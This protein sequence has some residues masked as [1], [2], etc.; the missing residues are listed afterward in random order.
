MNM[1]AP[2]AVSRARRRMT[3]GTG[4]L[5]NAGVGYTTN[6]VSYSQFSQLVV[7]RLLLRKLLRAL[8]L[9]WETRFLLT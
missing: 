4:Y 9:V 2:R 3:C 7:Y 1:T 6:E 8:A 5:V